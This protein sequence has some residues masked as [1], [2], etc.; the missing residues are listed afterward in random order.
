MGE[1]DMNIRITPKQGITQAIKKKLED[2]GA[3]VN[4]S[5]WTQ[6]QQYFTEE[7]EGEKSTLTSH[8]TGEKEDIGELW[9]TF[10]EW[11]VHTEKDDI[12]TIAEKT[13]EKILILVGLKKSDASAVSDES[14]VK[15]TAPADS[16]S[17]V[18]VDAT[19][20]TSVTATA[21]VPVSQTEVA[22]DEETN[23][24]SEPEADVE[25]VD[26][27][28]PTADESITKAKL[29]KQIKVKNDK[30]IPE[31]T[32]PFTAEVFDNLGE[33]ELQ[34]LNTPVLSNVG[35]KITNDDKTVTEYDAQGRVVQ[36]R[37]KDGNITRVVTREE[38]GKIK[39]ITDYKHNQLSKKTSSMYV[40][41]RDSN[42]AVLSEQYCEFDKKINLTTN[43]MLNS[44]FEV[45]SY[46]DK[47]YKRRGKVKKQIV[48]NV[49]GSTKTYKERRP[50][51]EII[52]NADGSVKLYI[53]YQY[54]RKGNVKKQVNYNPDGTVN[55]I[56]EHKYKKGKP[57]Q[58]TY[59][60][61]EG[62]CDGCT[63]NTY[64]KKGNHIRELELDTDGSVYSC[65]DMEYD[66]NGNVI[67]EIE[68]NPDGSVK[69]YSE[70]KYDEED[71]LI[72]TIRRDGEGKLIK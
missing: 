38:D 35:Q 45:K 61:S 60:T 39:N 43:V 26:P 31:Q 58:T 5:I 29:P 10:E 13:W 32:V 41:V 18:P 67:K 7:A 54:D 57:V 55:S 68:R 36:E 14:Q 21:T 69:G 59:Y 37:D 56:I 22:A 16:T 11:D 44:D 27:E 25:E 49:N 53:T 40:I 15:T 12:V 70:Y 51:K 65:T 64:D 9:E 6:V 28:P 30:K 20:T 24:G 2:N 63:Y 66:A 4:K 19:A 62:K 1:K 42:G 46:K 3:T 72:Q 47:E 34:R 8:T 33:A 50:K 48:D 23:I 71:K 17:T 52:R